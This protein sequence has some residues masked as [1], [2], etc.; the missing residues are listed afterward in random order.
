MVHAQGGGA[1]RLNL[2]GWNYPMHS[3]NTRAQDAWTARSS[4]LCRH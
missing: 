2:E 1:R 3:V 4:D